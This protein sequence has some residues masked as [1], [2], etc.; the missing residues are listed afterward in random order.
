M[1][2]QA[3]ECEVLNSRVTGAHR[4]HLK[5]FQ[6]DGFD[7]VEDADGCLGI[8]IRIELLIAGARRD[9]LKVFQKNGFDFVE[10]ADGRLALSAVPL[11]QKVRLLTR[12]A[13]RSAHAVR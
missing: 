12:A 1:A 9:H 2:V 11:S 6:K 3:Q 4:D 5:M 13:P 8:R 10:G 7:F